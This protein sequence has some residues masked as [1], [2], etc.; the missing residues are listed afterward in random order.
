MGI[1]IKGGEVGRPPTLPRLAVPLKGVG[2]TNPGVPRLA[3]AQGPVGG[4]QPL[5]GP[6]VAWVAEMGSAG[7]GKSRLVCKVGGA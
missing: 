5:A 1:G 2:T 4:G 7:G 3:R 6:A